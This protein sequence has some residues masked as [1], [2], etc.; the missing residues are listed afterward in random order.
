VFDADC[1]GELDAYEVESLLKVTKQ[2]GSFILTGWGG[3][4]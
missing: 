1:D 3:M 4:G 2:N